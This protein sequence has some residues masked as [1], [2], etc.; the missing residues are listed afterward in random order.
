VWAWGFNTNGQLGNGTYTDSNVPVAVSSLT[1]VTT[2]AGARSHSLA[3]MSDGTVR[4]W[5]RNNSGQLGDGTNTSGNVPVQVSSLTGIISIAGGE[6]H[7]LALKNDGTEWTFGSNGNGE[8]GIGTNT[9]SNVPVQVSGLCP[10]LD[11]IEVEEQPS[12]S[13]FPNPAHDVLNIQFEESNVMA[14]LVIYD[15]QG[16]IIVSKRIQQEN[17]A[18]SIRD[19]TPGVYIIRLEYNQDFLTRKLMVY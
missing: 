19:L 17:S 16:K 18:I 9:N 15:T 1:G 2:I 5:G 7:S 3:I 13:V 4:A 6:Q 11:V 12:V 14:E 10:V 8:L